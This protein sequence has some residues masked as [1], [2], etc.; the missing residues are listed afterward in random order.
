MGTKKTSQEPPQRPLKSTTRPFNVPSDV[1]TNLPLTPSTTLQIRK[2]PLSVPLFFFTSWLNLVAFH[3]I[4]GAFLV[5]FFVHLYRAEC[6][7]HLI[8]S[9][10]FSSQFLIQYRL[11]P[12]Q[13]GT[14]Y[15]VVTHSFPVAFD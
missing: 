14:S 11:F 13:L 9:H 1:S 4:F 6:F 12:H 3:S 8:E 5:N 15:H 2:C 7:H 10:P